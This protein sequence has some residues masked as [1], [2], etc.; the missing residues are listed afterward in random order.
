VP[1]RHASLS[2]PPDCNTGIVTTDEIRHEWV[3][4]GRIEFVV[5]VYM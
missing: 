2:K 4:E 5:L 1:F 3:S